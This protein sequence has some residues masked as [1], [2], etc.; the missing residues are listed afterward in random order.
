M[1]VGTAFPMKVSPVLLE[2][3]LN[4]PMKALKMI[5]VFMR[6]TLAAPPS[7]WIIG[8]SSSSSMK[9]SAWRRS[10]S[11][12]IGG[13]VRIVEHTDTRRPFRCTASTSLR[14]SPSPEKITM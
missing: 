2:T 1:L 8:F 5:N 7:R 14:K 4:E 13:W 11:E 6:A 3:S 12:T 10:S 9:L